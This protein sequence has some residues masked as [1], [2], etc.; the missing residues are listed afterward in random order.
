MNLTDIDV[1]P[2]HIAFDT[3]EEQAIARGMR[4]TGSEIVGLTPLQAILEAGRY[5]LKKQ[6]MSTAVSEAELVR[7]AI[8]SLGLNDISPFKPEEK[9]IEYRFRRNDSLAELTINKFADV[10]ASEAP[11]P[12]GGS[13]AALCGAL[14]S[15]LAAMV[16]N[17]TFGKLDYTAYWGEM[18][19]VGN[20]AQSLKE[21]FLNAIDRDT[22]A[23][24][25]VMEAMTLPKSTDEEKAIRKSALEKAN[26]SATLV[27]LEVLEKTMEIIPLL[28][29]TA[30]RGN[31]N[32]VSD[33]GVGAHCALTCAESAGLNVKIN[34]LGMKEKGFKEECLKRMEEALNAVR[35]GCKVVVEVVEGKLL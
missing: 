24:N 23:F 16:S 21:W 35:S 5:Y 15:A 9:I 10:L 14:A 25:A 29:A 1:T 28:R 12:G 27:P 11:A 30:E 7:T 22:T 4:V 18:E 26:K 31:V 34:L 19:E 20:K 13:T 33:A 6:G 17:L 32:S 3:V 8:L 2:P